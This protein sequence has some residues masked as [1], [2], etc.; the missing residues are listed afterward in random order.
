MNYSKFLLNFLFY[1]PLVMSVV[2]MVAASFFYLRRERKAKIPEMSTIIIL[3]YL[4]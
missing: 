1:Y 3:W 4:S 2:W